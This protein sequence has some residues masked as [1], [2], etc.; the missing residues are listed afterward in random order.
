[1]TWAIRLTQTQTVTR[2]G[3]MSQIESSEIMSESDSK[4]VTVRQLHDTVTSVTVSQLLSEA[5]LLL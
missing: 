5:V 3:L 2:K 4:L 1:M